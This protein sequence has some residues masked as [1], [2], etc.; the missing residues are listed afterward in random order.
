MEMIGASFRFVYST[1]S[2]YSCREPKLKGM[3]FSVD[4]PQRLGYRMTTQRFTVCDERYKVIQF[5]GKCEVYELQPD[6]LEMFL[7]Y[8]SDL[9][10][11]ADT[12]KG[13]VRSLGVA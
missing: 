4:P 1:L 3:L 12:D 10:N 11:D 7:G 8:E 13:D 9:V 2:A 6:G 5:G